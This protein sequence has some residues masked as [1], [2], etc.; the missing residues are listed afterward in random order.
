MTT[1]QPITSSA[2]LL[3]LHCQPRTTAL[4]DAAVAAL[5][6]LLPGW[7][8]VQ[9]QLQRQFDFSNYYQTMAFANALA[10]VSHT[11]DHHPELTISYKTCLVRYA[12][13][14][15]D[16]GN[17]GLSENDFICAAQAS[18]LYPGAPAAK[19]GA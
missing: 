4:T 12:T 2:D 5:L 7:T 9:N 18:A 17:G 13:H 15:V 1:P 6:P 14:S 16:N 8:L 11:Q 3:A 19:A 10:Y